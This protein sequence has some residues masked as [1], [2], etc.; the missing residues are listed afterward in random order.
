MKSKGS[1]SNVARKSSPRPNVRQPLPHEQSRPRANAPTR[2]PLAT[3]NPKAAVQQKPSLA[4]PAA[5]PVYRPQPTPAVLQ[6]KEP[7]GR[8]PLRANQTPTPAPAKVSTRPAAPPVYRPQ[9]AP[10]VLQQKPASPRAQP[11]PQ[12]PAALT[13]ARPTP[14]LARP[15]VLQ[16]MEEDDD[17]Q[18]EWERQQQFWAQSREEKSKLKEEKANTNSRSNNNNTTTNITNVPQSTVSATTS[19]LSNFSVPYEIFGET[20]KQK[21]RPKAN[22]VSLLAKVNGNTVGANNGNNEYDNEI[23]SPSAD[24]C[25]F[26]TTGDGEVAPL[27]GAMHSFLAHLKKPSNQKAQQNF[28]VSIF[29]FWGACDGCKQRLVK[30]AQVWEIEARRY[31]KTGVI[32]TLKITYKYQYPAEIFER[33]WGNIKYGWDEDGENGPCFHTIEANVTGTNG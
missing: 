26:N 17:W 1:Q 31:M 16:L 12:R 15:S 29:G 22:Q 24:V 2:P 23:T 33:E 10:K 9:S 4:R 7:A 3:P 14:P 25:V 18:R 27:L 6:R 21:K 5:P 30:F 11:T 20:L 8:P 13:H 19:H 28:T 32:A